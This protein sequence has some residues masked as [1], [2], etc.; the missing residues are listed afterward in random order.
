MVKVHIC[1]ILF[2]NPKEPSQIR[3]YKMRM[4][5]DLQL[6]THCAFLPVTSIKE[7]EINKSEAQEI[8]ATVLVLVV[9]TF[10]ISYW[11]LKCFNVS[12]LLIKT[13]SLN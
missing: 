1:I 3:D 4:F 2:Y 7:W 6:L 11:F 9:N 5:T 12:I 10:Y 13:E 8:V